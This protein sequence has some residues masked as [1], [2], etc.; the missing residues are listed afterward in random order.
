MLGKS[1]SFSFILN[2]VLVCMRQIIL[3][4]YRHTNWCQ[5]NIFWVPPSLKR[6]RIRGNLYF[7]FL[8]NYQSFLN[9]AWWGSAMSYRW[10]FKENFYDWIAKWELI[11][12][13][14]PKNGPIFKEQKY[15]CVSA[16]GTKRVPYFITKAPCWEQ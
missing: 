3:Y 1:V 13:G 5:A 9:F 15:F 8:Q 14:R 11:L 12:T 2:F 7:E 16:P 4:R 10:V 6:R